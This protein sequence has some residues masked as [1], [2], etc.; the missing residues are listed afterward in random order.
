MRRHDLVW[1]DPEAPWQALGSADPARLRSWMQARLPL[2][3]ARRDPAVDGADLRLG[4]A[5]PLDEQRQRLSLRAPPASVVRHAPPCRLDQVIASV[6]A[7]WQRALREL[8]ALPAH[9]RVAPRVYGSFA[10]QALTG[11]EYVHAGSDLD[12]LWDVDEPHHARALCQQIARWEQ[13]QG[14]RA[15]GELRRPDGRAVNWREYA[16]TSPTL[17]VKAETYCA[18]TPRAQLFAQ[19]VAA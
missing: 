9:A 7:P 3:V 4:V 16:G 14:I 12:L 17:L 11:L 19:A 5:L 15:D 1:L 2:V 6:A 13:T 10:W 8:A 18:L